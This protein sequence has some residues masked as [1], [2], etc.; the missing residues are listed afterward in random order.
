MTELMRCNKAKQLRR[1][2][3]PS[4]TYKSSWMMG[5]DITVESKPSRGST[6]TIR[7]PRIVEGPKEGVAAQ[8]ADIGQATGIGA[9]RTAD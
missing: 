1:V 7:L 6:F 2:N 3:A 4:S 9:R 8:L 5:G